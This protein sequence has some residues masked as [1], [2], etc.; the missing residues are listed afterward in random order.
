MIG[1]DE[2]DENIE[3]TEQEIEGLKNKVVDYLTIDDE[4]K[5][6]TMK[7]KNKKKEKLMLSNDVLNFMNEFNIED[8]NA[9]KGILKYTI[10]KTKKSINKKDMLNK[11]AIFLKSTE[12]A[13][14]AMSFIYDNREIVEKV[15]LKRLKPKKNLDL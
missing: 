8:L 14:E 12:K 9:E 10:S 3:I 5:L 13:N 2:N 11:L 6:L 4:I 7:L 1:N 15:R